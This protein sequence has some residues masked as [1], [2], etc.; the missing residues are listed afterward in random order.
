MKVYEV[1]FS[2]TGGTKKVS[3]ILLSAFP[4]EKEEISLLPETLDYSTYEFTE[5]DVCLIA[6]PSFGGRVPETASKRILSMKGNSAR[7][8]PVC[9][10]GNRAYE[11]TLLELKNIAKQAGFFPVCAVAA[12]A[13]H[14]IMR[15]FAAG[16]PDMKDRAELE[17]FANTIW[18][19]LHTGEQLAE[20][21]VPGNSDYKQ[22]GTIPFYPTAA[23]TCSKCGLCA[24]KCPVGAIDREHSETVDENKCISC[25]RCIAVCPKGARSVNK[26]QLTAAS[27]RMAK[28]FETRKGNELFLG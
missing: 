23:D 7:A 20:V 17:R 14:S 5:E 4:C 2:P 9:V 25:M 6:V 10:F 16:R 13:E 21:Q 27:Q 28:A 19:R 26:E 15:Q 1:T 3:D 8:V 18:E 11:D 24:A 12:V 22:Y